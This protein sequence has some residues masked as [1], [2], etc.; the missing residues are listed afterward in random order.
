M[1]ENFKIELKQ[2]LHKYNAKICIYYSG[3]DWEDDIISFE[4]KDS[5]DTLFEFGGDE[6][7][8]SNIFIK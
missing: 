8:A 2:L 5:G 1:D 3:S 7:S 4:E 6:L